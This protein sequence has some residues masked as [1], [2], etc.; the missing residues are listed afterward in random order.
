MEGAAGEREQRSEES[1]AELQ[2]ARDELEA[3]QAMKDE[4]ATAVAASDFEKVQ[5]LAKR[6]KVKQLQQQLRA[7]VASDDFREVARLGKELDEYAKTASQPPVQPVPE[8]EPSADLGVA[9]VWG[10]TPNAG[11]KAAYRAWQEGLVAGEIAEQM[12]LEAEE[13]RG[14]VDPHEMASLQFLDEPEMLAPTVTVV[15]AGDDGRPEAHVRWRVLGPHRADP[16]RLVEMTTSLFRLS[17][18]HSSWWTWQYI[19]VALNETPDCMRIAE[20]EDGSCEFILKAQPGQ[21]E[22]PGQYSV[23]VAPLY[24]FVEDWAVREWS[25]ATTFVLSP[26]GDQDSAEQAGSWCVVQ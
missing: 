3:V 21:L 6:L 23:A 2:A 16:T 18:K 22:H 1:A 17:F 13:Q 25:E 19:D 7:A 11:A 8:P 26:T 20:S 9:A 4:L 5:E 12:G 10:Q 15:A 14:T 24:E